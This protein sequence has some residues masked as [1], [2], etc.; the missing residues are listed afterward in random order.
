[1]LIRALAP[2]E[3]FND[4]GKVSTVWAREPAYSGAMTKLAE[5]RELLPT[6]APTEPDV[7]RV[8]ETMVGFL[9]AATVHMADFI[10][11]VGAEA[12]ERF[13][14]SILVELLGAAGAADA[15]L[16][17][18]E[19]AAGDGYEPEGGWP[20][21]PVAKAR[22]LKWQEA[23]S[24]TIGK[25]QYAAAGT[26]GRYVIRPEFTEAN[27]QFKGFLIEHYPNLDNADDIRFVADGIK[28]PVEAK[29]A[30]QADFDKGGGK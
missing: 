15:V 12:A 1:M 27:H 25:S 23:Q 24:M 14:R 5:L 28:K 30:A 18:V 6:S 2:D 20:E 9:K 11:R 22:K 17:T 21:A 19:T 7:E 3:A 4:D 10:E 26:T 29:A 13:A 8:N 16:A